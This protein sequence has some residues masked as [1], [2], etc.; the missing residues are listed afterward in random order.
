VIKTAILSC[1]K[2]TFS[3]TGI[4]YVLMFFLVCSLVDLK[5]V[6]SRFH[7]RNLNDARPEMAAL[8][9]FNTGDV[10][11]EKVIWAPYLRYFSLVLKYMPNEAASEMFLGVCRYY[12]QGQKDAAWQLMRHSVDTNPLFFWN[13]YNAGILAF[14]RGDMKSALDYFQ[15]CLVL[16]EDRVLDM[17]RSSVVYRQVMNSSNFNADLGE[18]IRNIKQDVYL[19]L[20][21]ASFYSGDYDKARSI[22]L[23]GLEKT[24]PQDKEPFF[25]YAGAAT[26]SLGDP[27]AALTFFGTCVKL[28]S[29]N[30]M[31]YNYAGQILKASGN[32]EAASNMFLT[33]RSLGKSQNNGFPYTE[34]LKLRLF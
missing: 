34:R 12:A 32:M 17:M 11:P 20:A 9:S 10:P 1:L 14:E 33:A 23:Y 3:R 30:P 26:L 4:F 21:A 15:K 28:K 7:A 19:F 25:F 13:I 2:W 8:V 18:N 27:Q 16:P 5:A 31:V 29:Q 22:A 24:G 6:T